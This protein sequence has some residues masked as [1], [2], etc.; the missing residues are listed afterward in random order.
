MIINSN[1]LYILVKLP[2]E[3]KIKSCLKYKYQNPTKIKIYE[4]LLYENEIN[5]S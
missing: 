3:K 2:D 1:L 5:C 4:G